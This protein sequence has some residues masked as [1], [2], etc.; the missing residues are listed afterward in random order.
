MHAC[1]SIG[2]FWFTPEKRRRKNASNHLILNLGQDTQ[3][4]R[5]WPISQLRFKVLVNFEGLGET[6]CILQ[7]RLIFYVLYK[8]L[9]K[10][11]AIYVLQGGRESILAALG[12]GMVF[13]MLVLIGS[14]H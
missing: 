2:D 14:K 11:R 1:A 8:V 5:N 9:D 6:F 10:H 12:P 7:V 13:Q 3:I 4:F